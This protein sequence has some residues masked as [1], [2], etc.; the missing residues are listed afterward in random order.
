M[1]ADGF[2]VASSTEKGN[3]MPEW[4]GEVTGTLE[5]PTADLARLSTGNW[6]ISIRPWEDLESS[7]KGKKYDRLAAIFKIENRRPYWLKGYLAKNRY[8][9]VLDKWR[10]I[11]GIV[12]PTQAGESEEK[13][14][15]DADSSP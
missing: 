1:D 7:A 9:T 2:R 13:A 15:G 10:A 4:F 14:V 12:F 5:I 8:L 11:E 6:T 3:I